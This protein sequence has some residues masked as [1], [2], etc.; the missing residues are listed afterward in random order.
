MGNA[1]TGGEKSS[2]ALN[3]HFTASGFAELG[4]IEQAGHFIPLLLAVSLDQIGSDRSQCSENAIILL[5]RAGGKESALA[6]P[7]VR[8]E[9]CPTPKEIPQSPAMTMDCSLHRGI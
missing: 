1:T 4:E 5:V 9:G 3:Q 6:L 7:E 2:L 8:R